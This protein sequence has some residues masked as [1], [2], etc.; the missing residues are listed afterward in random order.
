MRDLVTLAIGAAAGFL[1]VFG[2]PI[3]RYIA[4]RKTARAASKEQPK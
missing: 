1:L 3:S 2:E 4:A